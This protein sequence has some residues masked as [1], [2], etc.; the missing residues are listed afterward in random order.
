MYTHVSL[1]LSLT[2]ST[3]TARNFDNRI[4]SL[5]MPMSRQ[6]VR[7]WPVRIEAGRFWHVRRVRKVPG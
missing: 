3:C 1:S 7:V 2:L 6:A 5:H 4:A